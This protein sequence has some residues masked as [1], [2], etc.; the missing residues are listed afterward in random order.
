VSLL[1]INEEIGNNAISELQTKYKSSSDRLLFIKCD[2]TN[3]IE[4]EGKNSY[5]NSSMV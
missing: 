2:V 4:F 3:E 1:D 5:V